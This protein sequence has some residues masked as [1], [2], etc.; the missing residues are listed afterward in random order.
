MTPL[1]IVT[2]KTVIVETTVVFDLAGI[3]AS[4]SGV[5]FDSVTVSVNLTTDADRYLDE[6][7][8]FRAFGRRIMSNKQQVWCEFFIAAD[9]PAAAAVRMV[10]GEYLLASARI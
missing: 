5:D 3:V 1:T 7:E 6:D 10:I 2:I 8:G 9:D 4:S